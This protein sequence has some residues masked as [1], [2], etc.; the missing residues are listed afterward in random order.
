MSLPPITIPDL[1]PAGPVDP[2]NDLLLIRQGLNDRKVLAG[3]VG[4]VRLQQYSVLPGQVVASDM[5]LIGRNN[6]AG[7]TNYLLPPQY[8]GFLNGVAMW[9]W[10]SSAPMGWT[11]IPD[12][13]DRVLGIVGGGYPTPGYHGTWQQDNHT[14][15][16]DEI[17]PHR[18]PMKFSS[19]SASTSAQTGYPRAG[20]QDDFTPGGRTSVNETLNLGHNHGNS[21]RPAAAVGILCVKDRQIGQ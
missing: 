11:I 19:Q 16:P 5:L 20:R 4:S 2:N 1:D 9:F 15:T 6:G 14:L 12:A 10:L 3:Q 13:A 7:Y 21:W 18:H 8:L 17:P